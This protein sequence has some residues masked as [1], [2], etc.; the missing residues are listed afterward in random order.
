MRIT[1]LSIVIIARNEQFALEKCLSSAAR[2]DLFNCE[3]ICVDSGS[4]DNT[5]NV[6][7]S[8]KNSIPDLKILH[9]TGTQN[10]SIAR[11]A[12]LARATKK[13]VFF[14]DGDI[15]LNDAFICRGLEKL[16]NNKADAVFGML[17]DYEY[18]DDYTEIQRKLINRTSINKEE[19]RY[20]C[21]GIFMLKRS[22]TE[23]IGYFDEQYTRCQ[24]FDYTLRVT[25]KYKLLALPISMGIHHTIPYTNRS[26]MKN[27]I[28]NNIA[29]FYGAVI[30]KNHDNYRGCY[31]HI[32][33]AGY[34]KGLFILLLL[35]S[36]L[37][38]PPLVFAASA[39]FILDIAVGLKKRQNL[40]FRLISH[41]QIPLLVTYG[42][43]KGID[44]NKVY[45][46]QIVQIWPK[47]P[48]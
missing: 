32:K 24:D 28:L 19:Q 8:Y 2:L 31:A 34:L 20:L 26:R 23:D 25:R 1:D 16:S 12:G 42:F 48:A 22:I 41:Y 9:I 39:L 43:I 6:A 47:P 4:T 45:D 7:L 5:Q 27:E 38:Y 40:V 18:N 11:N 46:Y 10:A 15:E 3:I 35:I 21:G 30:R 17:E 13:Y 36:A 33:K 37:F 44:T 29:I 14:V